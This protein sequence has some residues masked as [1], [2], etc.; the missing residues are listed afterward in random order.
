[1]EGGAEWNGTKKTQ[2][3]E[4]T[5][6]KMHQL[7]CGVMSD[8]V[9]RKAFSCGHDQLQSVSGYEKRSNGRLYPIKISK[10][11]DFIDGTNLKHLQC[12]EGF[13]SSKVSSPYPQ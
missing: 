3:L 6:R 9:L 7:Y 2:P 5:G 1:M 13:P 10:I 8:F 12:S 11:Y 4:A